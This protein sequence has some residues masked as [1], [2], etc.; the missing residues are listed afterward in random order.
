[1]GPNIQILTSLLPL[2]DLMP[3]FSLIQ[4]NTQY[5]SSVQSLY[6]SLTLEFSFLCFKIAL[7]TA[8]GGLVCSP[9]LLDDFIVGEVE[10]NTFGKIGKSVLME[11]GG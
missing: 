2:C 10:G 4:Y 5:F 1:M 3:V 6:H 8:T 11:F 7:H 9:Q